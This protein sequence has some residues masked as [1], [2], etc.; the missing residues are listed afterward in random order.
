MKKHILTAIFLASFAAGAAIAGTAPGT[1]VVGSVH[2]MNAITGLTDDTQGRVCAF[3]HTPHHA[4]PDP[5]G[6]QQ[7]LWSHNYTGYI[8]NWIPYQSPTLQANITDPL[9]GPSRLCMSCHDGVVAADQ[10][11]GGG[12]TGSNS[13]L[14]SDT[15]DGRAIG[16]ATDGTNA[17]F[18][19]DHPIGFSYNAAQAADVGKGL[20]PATG[21]KF[22][23]N[24]RTSALTV[25]DV[26]LNGEFMTCA[27]CHDVHNKDNASNTIASGKN[28]L[29]YAP[30]DAS[31]LCLTCHNKGNG[32]DAGL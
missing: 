20:F 19:N 15:W 26:L 14:T 9:M 22:I 2:D 13:N 29:V 31:A 7:P 8:N 1:G 32:T 21:R 10:H 16:K 5:K 24:T 6:E 27:S 3:C 23:N 18:S 11:Y 12:Q 30:Q 4:M 25:A 28:Y 17:D